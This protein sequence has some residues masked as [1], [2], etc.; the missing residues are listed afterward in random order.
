MTF[1]ISSSFEL[2]SA[3]T[4]I[5]TA[6]GIQFDTMWKMLSSQ[7]L[8]K[9]VVSEILQSLDTESAIFSFPDR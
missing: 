1:E 9:D 3:M 4:V 5:P 7:F 8:S 2:L 6:S